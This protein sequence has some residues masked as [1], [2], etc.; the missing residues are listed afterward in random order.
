ML[1]SDLPCL[2]RPA[3][4]EAVQISVNISILLAFLGSIYYFIQYKRG[5]KDSGTYYALTVSILCFAAAILMYV[6]ILFVEFLFEHYIFYLFLKMI[7]VS[8]II[9]IV[10]YAVKNASEEKKEK[11]KIDK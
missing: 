4:K 8:L 11:T 3:C 9:P 5:R 10:Y 1:K 7:N 2:L 6:R